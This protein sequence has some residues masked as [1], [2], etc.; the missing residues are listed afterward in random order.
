M[1]RDSTHRFLQELQERKAE[2][3]KVFEKHKIDPSD[4][5]FVYDKRIDFKACAAYVYIHKPTHTRTHRRTHALTRAKLFDSSHVPS[6]SQ[7]KE[8]SG[9]DEDDDGSAESDQW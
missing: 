9:W 2:M 6:P 1:G 3:S 4:P 5:D 8:E 7:A